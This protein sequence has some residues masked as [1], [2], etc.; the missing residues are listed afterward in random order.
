MV[1]NSINRTETRVEIDEGDL[2]WDSSNIFRDLESGKT[3]R[4]LCERVIWYYWN[5]SSPEL[6]FKPN[7]MN[8]TFEYII[9]VCNFFVKQL[10]QLMRYK[11]KIINVNVTFYNFLS[12]LFQHNLTKI[13]CKW[14]I[15]DLKII[16]RRR[17][18]FCH[19]GNFW[20]YW[21]S[22]NTKFTSWQHNQNDN[23]KWKS[24]S[25]NTHPVNSKFIT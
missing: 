11:N 22:T 20:I 5:V 8:F 15:V 17:I 6:R 10:H 3:E 21:M 14:K 1:F 7:S 19:V 4:I 13:I 18:N 2:L 12:G 23:G 24:R 25:L 16:C 9:H